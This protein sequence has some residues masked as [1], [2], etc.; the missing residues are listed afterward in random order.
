MRETYGEQRGRDQ[1]RH[2]PK[3][4]NLEEHQLPHS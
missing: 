1:Q 2:A 3:N 4:A